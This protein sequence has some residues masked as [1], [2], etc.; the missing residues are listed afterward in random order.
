MKAK[1]DGLTNKRMKKQ[2]SDFLLYIWFFYDRSLYILSKS[3]LKQMFCFLLLFSSVSWTISS[4][5]CLVFFSV[6]PSKFFFLVLKSTVFVRRSFVYYLI[7]KTSESFHISQRRANM[8]TFSK[9]LPI[10]FQTSV[11]FQD[12]ICKNQLSLHVTIFWITII[13][14]TLSF[15]LCS[16]IVMKRWCEMSHS[17]FFLMCFQINFTTNW[18]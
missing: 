14:N 17:L 2:D 8:N 13:V 5:V 7:I 16:E 4:F 3:K 6:L 10:S 18:I 11:K 12:F 1:K 15:F 9:T